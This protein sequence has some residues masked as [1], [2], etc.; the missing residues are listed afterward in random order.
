M[1]GRTDGRITDD[2]VNR[3][4]DTK[5][6]RK[7]EKEGKSEGNWRTPRRAAPRSTVGSMERRIG[8]A[9]VGV[10]KRFPVMRSRCR[11]FTLECVVG[12]NASD[13]PEVQGKFSLGLG[14]E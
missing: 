11:N 6:I 14:R 12:I 3:Q 5:R 13:I 4:N 7:F 2:T 1:D 9:G 10:R 8:R